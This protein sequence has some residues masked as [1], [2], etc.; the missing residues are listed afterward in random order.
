MIWEKQAGRELQKCWWDLNE[1]VDNVVFFS[2]FHALLHL[3][4][5]QIPLSEAGKWR[6]QLL[7]ATGGAAQGHMGLCLWWWLG[8]KGGAGGVPATGLW[9]ANLCTCQSTEKVCPWRW[10]HLARWCPLQGS[11]SS[12]W[13]SHQHR[14]WEHVTATT[15]KMWS[16]SAWVSPVDW[17]VPMGTGMEGGERVVGCE[18]WG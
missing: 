18:L 12:P 4:T 1:D 16:Y 7:W 17:V 11:K 8:D 3:L 14:S 13:S 5:L 10:A 9:K 15:R 6:H 2:S